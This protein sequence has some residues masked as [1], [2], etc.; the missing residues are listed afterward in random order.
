V[1]GDVFFDGS[2][3]VGHTL[4]HAPADALVGDQVAGQFLL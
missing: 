3:Q 4:K 1:G 2:F